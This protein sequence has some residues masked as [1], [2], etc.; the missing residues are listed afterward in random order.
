[1]AEMYRTPTGE[2]SSAIGPLDSP[3]LEPPTFLKLYQ[4]QVL[5]HEDLLWLENYFSFKSLPK[6]RYQKTKI[7]VKENTKLENPYL[8]LQLRSAS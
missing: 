5:S 4:T 3:P 2:A 7:K 1:M 8:S 6:L